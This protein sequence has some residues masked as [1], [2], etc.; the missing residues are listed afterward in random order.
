MFSNKRQKGGGSRWE[1]GGKE[2]G[3]IEGGEAII[4]MF[5]E[6]ILFLIK[7]PKEIGTIS[8]TPETEAGGSEFQP[9]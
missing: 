7:K 2:L 3:G 6:N 8:Y 9:V 1:E 4:R 5:Y